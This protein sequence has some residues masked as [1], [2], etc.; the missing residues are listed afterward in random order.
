MY[1]TYKFTDFFL[2]GPRAYAESNEKSSEVI[3]HVTYYIEVDV[4]FTFDYVQIL[5]LNIF[6]KRFNIYRT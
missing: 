1:L 3:S 6:G 5:S 4:N 2:Q